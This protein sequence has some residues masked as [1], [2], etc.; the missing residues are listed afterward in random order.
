MDLVISGWKPGINT[1]LLMDVLR[2]QAG[3]SLRESKASVDGLLVGEPIYLINLSEVSASE[4]RVICEE[5]GA[6]CG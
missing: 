3:M 5:L 1:I 2:E 4:L 6:V